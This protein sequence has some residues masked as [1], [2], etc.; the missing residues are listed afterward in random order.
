MGQRHQVYAVVNE[1]HGYD[2]KSKE[3]VGIHHQWLYGRTA[4]MLLANALEL[5]KKAGDY[6]PFAKASY[7]AAKALASVYSV[8]PRNGYWHQTHIL[9]AGETEDPRRGDNND[10]IT[11]IDFRGKKPRYCFMNIGIGDSTILQAPAFKPLSAEEYV[12]LYYHPGC[13][14]YQKEGD[15]APIEKEI[16]GLLKRLKGYKLLS[17]KDIQELFPKMQHKALSEV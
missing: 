3:V 2:V 4:L 16:A 7:E 10:G 8:D 12:R 5:H 11:V 17:F 15:E 6:G 1:Y 14:A 13:Y 9:D